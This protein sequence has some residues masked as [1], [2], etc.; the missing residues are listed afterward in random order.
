MKQISTNLM[1]KWIVILEWAYARTHVPRCENIRVSVYVQ[2]HA[3]VCEG[4]IQQTATLLD[5]SAI[6]PICDSLKRKCLPTVP[7]GLSGDTQLYPPV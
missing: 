4:Y 3:R 6:T 1:I 5:T 7:S 2:I